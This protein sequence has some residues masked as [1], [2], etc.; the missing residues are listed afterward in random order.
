MV[1]VEPNY[2]PSGL[3][4]Y[5]PAVFSEE[6]FLGQFLLAFEKI[7]L[8]RADIPDAPKPAAPEGQPATTGLL[9]SPQEKT[10]PDLDPRGLEQIIDGLAVLYVPMNTPAE[11]L[12]WLS[13][14][15]ALSL[16]AD[17]TLDR[18]REFVAQVIQLYAERGTQRN[19]EKLLEIFLKATPTVQVLDTDPAYFF[20]V[21]IKLPRLPNAETQQQM[22]IAQ[23]LVELEKPAHTDYTLTLETPSLRVG[24]LKGS[25]VGVN[26][27]LGT[28]A[29][30]TDDEKS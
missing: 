23:S 10:D 15:A 21:T 14:W 30:W 12:P 29:E 16:R 19:L 1:T 26:T 20:R 24:D 3:L 22:E 2:P 18:Q 7:L 27:L 13:E 11:F 9:G 25:V 6:Q 5:L 17:M 4:Q 8:G 28:A